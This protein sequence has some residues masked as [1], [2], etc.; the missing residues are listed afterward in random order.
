MPA[1]HSQDMN[2]SCAKVTGFFSLPS[3]M[4]AEHNPAAHAAAMAGAPAGAGTCAHCGTGILHHVEVESE[5]GVR[6]FIGTSCALK[7]GV[8]EVLIRT[9]RTSAEQA[10]ID[11]KQD[12]RMARF[13]AE[14]DAR[15]AAQVAHVGDLI[16]MLWHADSE[17]HRSLARQLYEGP[18]SERQAHFVAK[19]TSATGRRNKAN[20]AAWD[21]VLD[22]CITT[23][24]IL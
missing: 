10:E 17:F 20:A 2:L 21:D 11:A 1:G 3:P 12:A 24:T 8:S 7:V 14:R 18:L 5:A 13:A 4:L 19:V 22:R 15:R 9:R 6:S 16:K 23:T